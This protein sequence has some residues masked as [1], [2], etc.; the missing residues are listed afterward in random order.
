[1]IA[2]DQDPLGVQATVVSNANSQWTLNK[3]LAN[4]DKAVVLFNAGTT[5][6]GSSV[7]LSDL[8]LDATRPYIVRDLWTHE[9]TATQGTLGADVASHGTAMYRISADTFTNL[10]AVVGQ[11]STDP[12]VTSGLN[13]KLTAAENSRTAS[14]RDNQINAFVNLVTAQTGKALTADQASALI[15]LAN[16]LK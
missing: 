9:T 15:E 16:A 5:T 8:G 3:P 4:G 10:R 7:S 1:M 11:Y 13:D 12:D 6:T 2:V 14:A